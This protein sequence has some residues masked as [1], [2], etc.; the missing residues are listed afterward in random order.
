MQGQDH[1]GN[2]LNKPLVVVAGRSNVG[3]SSLVRALTGKR[4]RIGKRP[5]TTGHEELIDLESIVLVDMP[6]FGYAAGKDRAAINRLKTG[7]VHRLENWERRLLIAILVIDVSLFRELVERWES[8]N[9]VP[10][11]VEFYGFLSEISQYVIVAAN[12]TDKVAN[13]D[14]SDEFGFLRMKLSEV[15]QA[16]DII[17]VSVRDAE[18]IRDLRVRIESI[19]KQEGLEVPSW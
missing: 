14:K 9:E 10:V 4:V 12:K 18:S 17:P 1:S 13:K 11:D 7:I 16:P 5:G 19:L 6:G 15:G 3:K 2:E 8:R